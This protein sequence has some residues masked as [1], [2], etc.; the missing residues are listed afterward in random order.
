MPKCNTENCELRAYYGYKFREPLKCK[1]HRI[2]PEMI[3]VLHPKCVCGKARPIFGLET[4]E[5]ASCCVKC[6]SDIM[7]DIKNDK[8]K[9]KKGRPY[10]GL[11]SDKKGSHCK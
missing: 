10:F 7:I 8:C 1:D 11:K 9:C 4:D 2:K 5:K 3:H 6:K